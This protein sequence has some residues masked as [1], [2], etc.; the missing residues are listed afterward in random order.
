[1]DSSHLEQYTLLAKTATGRALTELV[2]QAL[3]HPRVFVF[4]ELLDMSN[5][6][7]MESKY[8]DL[9]RIFAYGTFKD[10]VEK[11]SQLP[12]LTAKHIRKLKLLTFVTLA[13]LNKFIKFADLQV[14]VDLSSSRELEDLIIEAVYQNLVVGKIDQE[15]QCF[16]VE[17]H[18]P[19]DCRAEDVDDIIKTLES[20]HETAETMMQALDA[21]D[22]HSRTSH[23]QHHAAQDEL[24][25]HVESVQLALRYSD[26]TK[27]GADASGN[28]MQLDDP[29]D[30]RKRGVRWGMGNV[31]GGLSSRGSRH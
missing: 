27:Q 1:M 24:E 25:K 29:D 10:Y 4:G 11:E 23:D 18:V 6:Q 16:V 19:R 7:E 20:W 5:V 9:L 12:A 26:G 22:Q 14:E 31:M 13:S 28:R 30:H 17:S 8:L 3:E 15:Q 2:L 21:M